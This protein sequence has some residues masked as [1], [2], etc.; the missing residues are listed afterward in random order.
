MICDL[1]FRDSTLDVVGRPS[2][3]S[4]SAAE[5]T[6]RVRRWSSTWCAEAGRRRR[7][8]GAPGKLTWGGATGDHFTG[9]DDGVLGRHSSHTSESRRGGVYAQGGAVTPTKL[10]PT[11]SRVMFR[12][13]RCERQ[14]M[15]P[16]TLTDGKYEHTGSCVARRRWQNRAR[17]ALRKR[18]APLTRI[19]RHLAPGWRVLRRR[20]RTSAVSTIFAGHRLGDR[21]QV[22]AFEPHIPNANSPDWRVPC[23]SQRAF[24]KR[25]RVL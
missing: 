6:S 20:R 24:R 11:S 19:D 9:V 13:Q 4:R 12:V 17:P 22:F 15:E 1:K 23:G 5:L 2:S 7:R 25:R 14:S 3:S 8:T 21:G 10:S 18:R 16:T